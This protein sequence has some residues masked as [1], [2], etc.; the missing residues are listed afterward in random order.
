M[1]SATERA[2]DKLK[3]IV[4]SQASQSVTPCEA[5]RILA[6]LE[7]MRQAFQG[8]KEAIDEAIKLERAVCVHGMPLSEGCW[9]CLEETGNRERILPT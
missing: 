3:S 4:R 6:Y 8:I 7:E 1:D 9:A 2:I 5:E